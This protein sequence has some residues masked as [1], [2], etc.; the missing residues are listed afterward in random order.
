VAPLIL[1]TGIKNKVLE[2]M[3]M[4]KCVVTTSIGSQGINAV[5]GEDLIITDDPHEFATW[6]VS[7][8]RDKQLRQKLGDNARRIIETQYS[9]KKI[10]ERLDQIF[11]GSVAKHK[12]R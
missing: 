8:L 10:A 7:L 1:G 6:V 9:W 12:E 4:G 3:A 2:A 11:A 5:S